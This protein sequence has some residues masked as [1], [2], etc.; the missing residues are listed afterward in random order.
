[1]N[2]SVLKDNITGASYDNST[3]NNG[4]SEVSNNSALWFH[5]S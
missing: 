5:V 2:G 1:M 3:E 4:T